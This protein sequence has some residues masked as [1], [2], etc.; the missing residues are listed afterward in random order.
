MIVSHVCCDRCKKEVNGL[1]NLTAIKVIVRSR[2]TEELHQYPNTEMDICE[3]C[4]KELPF[5]IGKNSIL[6]NAFDFMKKL[7][8]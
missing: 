8:K 2:N 4:L 7:F 3:D 1:R 6:S 5:D